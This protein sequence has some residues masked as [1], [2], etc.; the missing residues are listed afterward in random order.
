MNREIIEQA[1]LQH[2]MNE[3]GLDYIGEVACEKGFIAG[4]E[5]RI[6]SVWHYDLDKVKTR[7]KVLV[8]FTYNRIRLYNDIR[9]I[10]GLEDLFVCFAYVE[11]LLPERKEKTK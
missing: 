10:K 9:N 3:S 2:A 6:N 8:L 7:K 11:D 4:A 5:W 1:A